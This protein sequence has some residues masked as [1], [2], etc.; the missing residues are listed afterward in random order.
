MATF[1]WMNVISFDI[2]YAFTSKTIAYRSTKTFIYYNIY[3][4]GV[5]VLLAIIAAIVNATNDSVWSPNFGKC[6]CWFNEKNSQILF[7]NAPALIVFVF[8]IV[9]YGMAVHSIYQQFEQG[10]A[11]RSTVRKNSNKDKN[12]SVR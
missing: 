1:L 10:K 6:R 3:A 2:S 4:F 8:N 7:F 12:G 5:P 11:A 9:L